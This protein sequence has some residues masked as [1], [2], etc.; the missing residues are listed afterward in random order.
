MKEVPHHDSSLI[1]VGVA[2]TV[3][4]S[5]EAAVV[6]SAETPVRLA[7]S[8]RASPT[9]STQKRL[10]SW[11]QRSGRGTRPN[12]PSR[13]GPPWKT[14]PSWSLIGTLDLVIPPAL[15]EDMSHRAGAH[16]TK[17][18][19][20]HLSLITH[21]DDVTEVILSAVEATTAARPTEVAEALR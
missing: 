6:A 20:G 18:S 10:P 3:G 2:I 17:V 21:P 4:G 19:A 12:S 7:S 5:R 8:M 15:Q 14:I 11:P 1:G 9:G 16:I 13:Q